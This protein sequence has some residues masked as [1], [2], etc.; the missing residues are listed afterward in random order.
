MVG[1][2]S[3]EVTFR[4]GQVMFKEI[5]IMGSLGM[6]KDTMIDA[7]D[8]VGSGLIKPIVTESYPLEEINKAAERLSKG[9]VI[10]R[11]VIIP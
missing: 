7:V 4:V 9:E 8:L 6:K 5:S 10:G 1:S 2:F 3:P 11:S